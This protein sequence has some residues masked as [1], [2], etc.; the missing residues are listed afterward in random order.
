MLAHA[1][2]K[3]AREQLEGPSP[4]RLL[5]PLTTEHEQLLLLLLAEGVTVPHLGSKGQETLARLFGVVA[6]RVQC[7]PGGGVQYWFKLLLLAFLHIL[8]SM[9]ITF[10]LLGLL[11]VV[12]FL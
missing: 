11:G 7:G 6:E 3:V 2:Q 10:L 8:Y 5:L 1:V 12:G 4:Q 9:M